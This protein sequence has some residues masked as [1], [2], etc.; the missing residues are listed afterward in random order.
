MS[1]CIQQ[2]R[3]Q[4]GVGEVQSPQWPVYGLEPEELC[5]NSGKWARDYLVSKASRQTMSPRSLLISQYRGLFPGDNAAVKWSWPLSK[6]SA[7]IN[8]TQ[9]YA[10][11]RPYPFVSWC[12]ISVDFYQIMG[13]RRASF[14]R[15]HVAG[16]TEKSVD[17][18][19]F[20]LAKSLSVTTHWNVF[21]VMQ[22][23][24]WDVWRFI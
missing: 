17:L 8:N 19:F 22:F 14:S 21:S 23:F 16:V 3:V 18:H 9:K 24:K 5:L 7:K 10:Y 20:F 15:G 6:F 12:L 13:L 2:C 4:D 1:V 11:N